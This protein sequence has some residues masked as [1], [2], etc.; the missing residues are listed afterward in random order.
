MRKMKNKL[1][2]WSHILRERG[3]LCERYVVIVAVV[4]GDDGGSGGGG[5]GCAGVIV[6]TR[7]LCGYVRYSARSQKLVLESATILAW[8][9]ESDRAEKKKQK[10][11]AF[12][13]NGIHSRVYSSAIHSNAK[14]GI[15]P[16]GMDHAQC[17]P[18]ANPFWVK[19]SSV[20]HIEWGDHVLVRFKRI[21]CIPHFCA[22]WLTRVRDT[23][24]TVWV[25][26]EPCAKRINSLLCWGKGNEHTHTK[27]TKCQIVFVACRCC[28]RPCMEEAMAMV[29][30]FGENRDMNLWSPPFLQY[31]HRDVGSLRLTWI[32]GVTVGHG[33]GN[34]S[35]FSGV[36]RQFGPA[37]I[38][39]RFIDE[40][41]T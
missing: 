18:S 24:I 29:V 17:A 7:C 10:T 4:V 6:M 28:R 31:K 21:A 39:H 26:V 16:N 32:F 22:K 36:G 11:P 13:C 27:I 37:S 2:F 41:T 34:H 1:F 30:F 19:S 8:N 25:W 33:I 14:M 12:P 38:L 9:T 35:H 15:H 3:T 20:R 40:P 5:G 23:R